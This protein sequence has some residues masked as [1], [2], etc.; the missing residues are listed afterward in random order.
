MLLSSIGG[1]LFGIVVSFHIS[2]KNKQHS[3]LQI[4]F[5]PIIIMGCTESLP[6]KSC[7][8]VPHT[9]DSKYKPIGI[10]VGASPSSGSTPTIF[11]VKEKFFSWSGDDFKLKHYPTGDALGNGLKI[12]GKVFAL[13]DQ[14]TLLD[15]NGRMVAVLLRKFQVIGQTFKVY[16]ANPVY[17]GQPP[18]SQKY[19]NGQAL[20]TYCEIRRV[21]LSTT[22]EIIMD[23]KTTPDYTITRAG[24]FWPKSRLV[25]K[26]GQPAALMEGGTWEGSF[27]SYKI[28][29]C[30]GIDPCLM[31]LVC[32]ACDEM[33]EDK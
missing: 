21:P 17:D 9:I 10:H 32:A 20:Y 7:Y 19:E 12:K 6:E 24:A 25:K 31:A 8:T 14:M 13:R 28:T 15:G 27:N 18:S 2:H 23:G 1:S 4:Q 26:M 30:P 3:N 29:C 16:V 11:V 33:D 5:N 22:Q